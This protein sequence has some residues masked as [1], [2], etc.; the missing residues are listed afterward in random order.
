MYCSSFTT[1][2]A[3][4]KNCSLKCKKPNPTLHIFLLFSSKSNSSVVRRVFKIFIKYEHDKIFEF[5]IHF[6]CEY[7]FR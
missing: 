1:K 5:D 4:F 7:G 3:R 6:Y 2:H